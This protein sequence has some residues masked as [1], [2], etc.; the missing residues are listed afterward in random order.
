MPEANLHKIVMGVD[1]GAF[2]RDA[3]LPGGR[4]VLAIGRLVEKKG[5][6]VL[7]DALALLPDVTLRIVGDGPLR[8][9]LEAQAARCEGRVELVGS[10]APAQVRARARGRRRARDAVRRGA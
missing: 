4:R 1:V 10:R 5:F 3:P 9:Q 8:A 7:I 6:D 2:E